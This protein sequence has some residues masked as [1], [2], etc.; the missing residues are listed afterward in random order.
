MVLILTIS[1]EITKKDTTKAPVPTY[2][3]MATI[4]EQHTT[5]TVIA[6]M[7]ALAPLP[8]TMINNM[9]PDPLT[10]TETIIPAPS[11][12]AEEDTTTIIEPGLLMNYKDN[13]TDTNT[14]TIP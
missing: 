5:V 13:N 3:T 7:I 1:T 8:T 2:K 14:Y 12:S 6:T 9:A 4:G 10:T 11:S